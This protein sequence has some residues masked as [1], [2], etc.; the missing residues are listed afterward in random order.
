MRTRSLG[1]MSHPL[2][3]GSEVASQG[4]RAVDLVVCGIRIARLGPVHSLEESVELQ[5]QHVVVDLASHVD[6]PE[7]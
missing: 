4:S 3:G 5:R 1:R 6:L 2:V 7:D